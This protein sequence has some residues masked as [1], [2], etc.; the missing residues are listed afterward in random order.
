MI[1]AQ[2][3]RKQ[4]TNN[5]IS[6]MTPEEKTIHFFIEAKVREE[7]EKGNYSVFLEYIDFSELWEQAVN[8]LSGAR[9]VS[10]YKELGYETCLDTRF[11]KGF[12]IS[13]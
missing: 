7:V 4:V 8:V 3:A 1:N 6:T 13:W 11:A 10:Y 12:S 5:F 9:L 2:Q